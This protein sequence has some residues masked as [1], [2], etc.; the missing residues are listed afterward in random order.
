[1]NADQTTLTNQHHRHSRNNFDGQNYHYFNSTHFLFHWRGKLFDFLW[2]GKPA[3]FIWIFPHGWNMWLFCSPSSCTNWSMSCICQYAANGFKPLNSVPAS[4]WERLL[5]LQRSH[6][7]KYYLCRNRPTIVLDWSR[8][9]SPY[10]RG[11]LDQHLW[12]SHDV[13]DLVIWW[14]GSIAEIRRNLIIK[15]HPRNSV[16]CGIRAVAVAFFMT[17]WSP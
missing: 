7:V 9:H 3:C 17:A 12:T 4:E 1:M 6:Q 13:A 8:S 16:Y 5:S 10:H 14:S 2:E 15:D 11:S